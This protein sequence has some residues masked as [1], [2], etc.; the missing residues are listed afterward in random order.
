LERLRKRKI[1]VAIKRVSN[2][3]SNYSG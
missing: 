1:R 3:A 2:M